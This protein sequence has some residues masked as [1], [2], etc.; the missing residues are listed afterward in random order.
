[1]FQTEIIIFLQKFAC[2]PVTFFFRFLT[3]IGRGIYAV[4]MV[5]VIVF[6]VSYRAGYLLAQ[7]VAWNGLVTMSLKEFFSLPRP[8]NVD[9]NVKLL[10][11]IHHVP[12]LFI[13]EGAGS[14]FGRL[15]QNVVDYFRANPIDTLGFPS[16]HTSNAAV[17]WSSLYI[18]FKKTWVRALAVVMILFIPLSRMYLGRHFLADVLGGY[19]IGFLLFLL[20]YKFVYLNKGLKFFLYEK[21]DWFRVSLKS[22]MMF[23]YFFIMPFLLLPIPG[24][25]HEYVAAFLG[26]NLGFL[27][28]RKRGI[29]EDT[30]NFLQR[31]A[32]VMVAL[33][34]L[35]LFRILL[36]KGAGLIFS[37]EP[38]AIL[39]IR[40]ALMM[41][42]FF[43]CSTEL[44]VKLGLYMRK[45]SRV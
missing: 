4:P 41:L 1:V 32:R 37:A 36:E 34:I 6:G 9:I 24:V 27:L 17:F 19:L 22:V 11:K 38:E 10:G 39:F 43:W 18:F 25:D 3:E 14:F 7:A 12:T 2:G 45:K 30:G 13:S 20:F 31:A 35:V 44:C 8:S 5:T 42:L 40:N 15:P 29:P 23:I 28:I 16:G 26:F 21:P 33:G